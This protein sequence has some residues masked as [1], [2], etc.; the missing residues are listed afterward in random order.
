MKGKRVSPGD[1]NRRKEYGRTDAGSQK[2]RFGHAGD[3]YYAGNTGLLC[4]EDGEF[5]R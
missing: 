5:L 1:R 3:L 2:P 4:A